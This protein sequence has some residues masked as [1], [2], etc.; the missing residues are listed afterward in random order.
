MRTYK[1]CQS[2]GMPLAK[3]ELG[4]GTERDGTKSGMFCSHCYMNG[5]FT[6]P[7]ITVDEM[8][9]LVKGKIVEFGAPTFI[10]GLFTRNIPKLER[11]KR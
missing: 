3:D 6:H 5:E 1:N 9:A 7:N 11:W 4:G 10:A 2:C 8:K